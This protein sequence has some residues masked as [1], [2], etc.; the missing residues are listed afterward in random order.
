MYFLTKSE[1]DLLSLFNSKT[2]L[3]KQQIMEEISKK[4]NSFATTRQIE[5][6]IEGCIAKG[7]VIL[8]GDEKIKITDEGKR[9]I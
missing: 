5:N 9:Q 6:A 8:T 2:S 3:T 7:F 4:Q 1:K